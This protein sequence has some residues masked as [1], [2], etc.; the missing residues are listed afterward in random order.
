MKKPQL[1]FHPEYFLK[2][3]E[4]LL[5]KERTKR[6]IK[7][8]IHEAWKKLIE[9]F[10]ID[11]SFIE[12]IDV[13]TRGH[14]S[15]I[16]PLVTRN[17]V[18]IRL[19]LGM[20]IDFEKRENIRSIIFHEVYHLADRLD[21][22]FEM[23]YHLDSERKDKK[24]SN[25]INILW[26]LYIE[27]RKYFIYKIK[28]IYC[29]HAKDQDTIKIKKISRDKFS[30]IIRDFVEDTKL[31]DS[32]FNEAWDQSFHTTYLEIHRRSMKISPKNSLNKGNRC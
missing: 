11:I 5:N 2:D 19:D 24:L 27:K 22:K 30:E 9:V 29:I 6:I 26:D 15:Q 20:A 16:T 28:P 21:P 3:F 18:V 31:S 13:V 25:I 4:E 8:S 1:Y 7:E 23:D 10:D 17:K 32:I 14:M 12:Q